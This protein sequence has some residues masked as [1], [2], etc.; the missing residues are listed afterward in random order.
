MK[1]TVTSSEI[2]H[3]NP[4]YR[5]RHDKLIWPNGKPGN[6]YV[7]EYR[8]GVAILAIQEQRLLTVTQYRYTIDQVC[9]E[10]PM[11][12]SNEHETPLEAA[13]REL[14]EETGYRADELVPLGV[15]NRILGSTA[16]PLHVF[17]ATNFSQTSTRHL[18]DSEDGMSVEWRPISEW[19]VLIKENKIQD[20]DSIAAYGLYLLH[21]KR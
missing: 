17:L 21:S 18:D 12:G 16:A 7:S 19:E 3:E 15:I 9:I 4:W 2:I 11:G 6:Y 8:P 20:S 1:P 10:L 13:K 14:I 5:V